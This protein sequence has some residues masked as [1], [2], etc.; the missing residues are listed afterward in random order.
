VDFVGRYG[1]EEFVIL[2]QG[3]G[4]S[5]AGQ[6]CE[7]IRQSIE[8]ENWSAIAPNISVTISAG[9]CGDTSLANHEK[10]LQVADALLYRAKHRGKNRVQLPASLA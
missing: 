2:L 3:M 4:A 8:E 5:N 6:I 10:M 7:R 9:V 1:G